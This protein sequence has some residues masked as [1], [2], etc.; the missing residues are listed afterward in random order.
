MVHKRMAGGR[1]DQAID[2]ALAAMAHTMA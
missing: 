2:D 1:N